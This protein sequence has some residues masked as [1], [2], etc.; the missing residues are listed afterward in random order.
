MLLMQYYSH[1]VLIGQG[2]M[3]YANEDMMYISLCGCSKIPSILYSQKEMFIQY[4]HLVA[5][6]TLVVK[7]VFKDDF[8]VHNM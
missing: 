6:P 3:W 8:S 5:I 2:M 7:T 4:M 1:E